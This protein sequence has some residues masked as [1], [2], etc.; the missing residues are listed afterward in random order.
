MSVY[1]RSSLIAVVACLLAAGAAPA[2][3]VAL[4]GVPALPGGATSITGHLVAGPTDKG[5]ALDFVFARPSDSK[6]ITGFDVELTKQLHV[7]AVSDDLTIFL[8]DHVAHVAKNGHFRLRMVF[9]RPGLYHLYADSTPTGLGQQVLRFDLPVGTSDA[10]GHPAA[11]NATGLVGRDGDYSVAFD[12]FDLIAG[13]EAALKFHL[14]KGGKPAADLHPYLGVAAHAVFIDIADLSYLHVHASAAAASHQMDGMA[15]M[16][17]GSPA[18][19]PASAKLGPDLSLHVA[20]P[21]QGAYALWIQFIGG[22]EVRT[23]SFIVTAK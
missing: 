18:P 12:S 8:H 3:A 2:R 4:D 6:P 19:M 22:K 14:A 15:G 13:H 11:V 16:D 10:S 7:I 20:P 17:M 1:S 5:E 9:P 23:V 21:K